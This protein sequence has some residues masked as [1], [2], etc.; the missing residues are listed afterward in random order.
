MSKEKNF[1]YLDMQGGFILPLH[2]STLD[3]S[4]RGLYTVA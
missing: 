2:F 1:F 4:S 3:M